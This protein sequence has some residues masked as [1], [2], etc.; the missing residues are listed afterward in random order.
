M[1]PVWRSLPNDLALYVINF[2][3]DIEVRLA[4]KLKPRR[5]SF[6]KNFNFKNEYVYD[7]ATRTMFDFSGMSDPE[8]P[9]WIT[10]KGILFSHFR[11]PGLHIFN[12]EW[13]EYAMTMYTAKSQLGPT[14]CRNHIV[15]DKNVKFK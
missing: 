12:M 5:L 8:H 10:R 14:M 6:D 9:Y 13:D 4:F 3:D 2:L 7:R 15:L 1:D 11:S